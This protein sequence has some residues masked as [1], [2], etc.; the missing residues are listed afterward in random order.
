MGRSQKMLHVGELVTETAK[1]V[2]NALFELAKDSA[3]VGIELKTF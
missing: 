1:L 3:L 2:F